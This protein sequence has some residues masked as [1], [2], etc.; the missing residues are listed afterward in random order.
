MTDKIVILVTTGTLREGKRI[1]KHLVESRLAA[2]VNI[3]QPVRSIYRWQ[4]KVMD[5]REHLLWIKT[6]RRLFE[7]VRLAI[8]KMHS[9]TTPEVI[10]LPIVEGASDYLQWIDNSIQAERSA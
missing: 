1:A 6:T 4:G 10:A 5:D 9:Y 3:S 7:S 8:S 2:C